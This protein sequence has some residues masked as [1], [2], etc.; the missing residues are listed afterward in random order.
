MTDWDSIVDH[1]QAAMSAVDKAHAATETLRDKTDREA[2]EKFQAE[3]KDLQKHLEQMQE[4][5][6]HEDTYTIDELADALGSAMGSG[7]TYHRIAHYEIRH[8]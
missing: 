7:Q 6:A 5:L 4:I 2:V 3:M 1:I 8:K